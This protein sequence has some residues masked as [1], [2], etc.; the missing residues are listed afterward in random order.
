MALRV[1]ALALA[2]RGLGLGLGLDG[3]PGLGLGSAASHL[4]TSFTSPA[5][6]QLVH[7]IVAPNWK[8][9]VVLGL[10]QYIMVSA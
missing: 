5:F 4:V 1:Q 10:P 3:L 6:A 7:F 9:A 8:N 2:L